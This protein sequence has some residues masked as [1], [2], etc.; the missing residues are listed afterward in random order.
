MADWV[1]DWRGHLGTYTSHQTVTVY[2]RGVRQFTEHLA[3]D[4]PGVSPETVTRRHVEDFLAELGR[5][6]K[7]AATRRIRLMTL[8]SFFRWML[9]EPPTPLTADPTAG[10]RAPD[11]PLPPVR[12]VTDEHLS[13]VLA[14]CTGG[15]FASLCYAAIL[16]VFIACGLRRAE[17]ASLDL[18]DVDLTRGD[19]LVHGKGG[20]PR[21]V[22]LAGNKVSLA[23][24][25]Y[26][27]VRRKHPGAA[28]LG[29]RVLVPA[30]Q[31]GCI[32]ERS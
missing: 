30:A 12:V 8:K 14:T 5:T 7:A 25:R 28:H 24:S 26:L 17:V 9:A 3:V 1:R 23:L 27:R 22:S 6:G 2:L 10:V 4:H 21:L 13:A 29:G 18:A 15:D 11:V 19:L 31:R 32:R 16:R 20:K